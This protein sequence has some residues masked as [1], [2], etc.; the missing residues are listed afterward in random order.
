MPLTASRGGLLLGLS[1]LAIVSQFY[2]SSMAVIA[3]ELIDDL[4]LSPRTLGLAGGMFFLALGVAQIPVGMSFDRIGPRRTVLGVS[5]F[6]VLGALATASAE[7]AGGLIAGRFLLG[8]GCGASFMSA[9]VLLARWYPAERMATMYGRVFAVS[10]LGNLAAATPMAWMSQA[11]GWRAVF[12]ASALLVVAVVALFAAVAR[13]QP[14]GTPP[15]H[16]AAEPLSRTLRGFADVLRLPDF[17][18]VVAVHMVAYATMATVLGLWAGPYL[19]DV[20]GLGAIER[21]HVLLAMSAAQVAGLLWL[22]PLE[23]RLNTRKGVVIAAALGVVATLAAL[24]AIPEP[25]LWLAIALLV[26]LTAIATYSPIII[27]H[28][29]SIT[30]PP[31]RGRGAAAAN[32]GQVAG[33]FLMPVATGAIAGLFVQAS[34]AYP[35]I[36]YRL[37]FAFMAAALAIGVAVYSRAKDSRPRAQSVRG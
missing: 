24:A 36:A 30:P 1:L 6:A 28:V 8:F 2:R 26:A 14:A 33:S 20:H 10:Q 12:G 25:P 9:V 34:S 27:A 7:T 3:P 17:R 37:I 5:A 21:G 32:I 23:R 18:K 4:G 35:P 16:S 11:F 15:A 22:V 29:T 19:H 31:L 13:D